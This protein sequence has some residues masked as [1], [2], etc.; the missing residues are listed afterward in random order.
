MNDKEKTKAEITDYLKAQRKFNE[1]DYN[2]IDLFIDELIN[3]QTMQKTIDEEG[4]FLTGSNGI[5][6]T[7]PAIKVR[8]ISSKNV[9]AIG[10]LLGITPMSRKMINMELSIPKEIDPFAEFD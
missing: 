6:Y 3:C 5:V 9:I 4:S 8:N 7:H 1:I 2:L 10:K